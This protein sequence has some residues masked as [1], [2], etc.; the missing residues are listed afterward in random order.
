MKIAIVTDS[1][2][3]LNP[4]YVAKSGL[5]IVP[6][7]IVFGMQRHLDDGKTLPVDGL[8]R[9]MV[10]SRGTIVTN[11]PAVEEY[12]AAYYS[13][14]NRADHIISLHTSALLAQNITNARQAAQNF[15]NLVTVLDSR[16]STAAQGFQAQRLLAG[17][18]QGRDLQDLVNEQQYM[19]QHC[20]VSFL[21]DDLYF[22]RLNKRIGA[23]AAFLGNVLSLKPILSIQNG[24]IESTGRVLG[25]RKAMQALAESVKRYQ[26]EKGRIRLGFP[27]TPGGK[28][29]VQEL[30]TLLSDVPYTDMGNWP[31]GA[32]I[33]ANAGPGAIGVALEPQQMPRN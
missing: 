25:Y 32:S 6:S 16:T 30:R 19:A 9:D 13:L 4:E 31:L 17:V 7:H 12:Y 20:H 2:S 29:A 10:S 22:L 26:A 28:E 27:Y 23:A 5:Y 14:L 3:D 33:A 11:P 8:L 21:V 24:Q 15:G 1:T 18:A